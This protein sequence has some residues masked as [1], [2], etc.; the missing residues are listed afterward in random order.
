MH[1]CLANSIE[2]A[3]SLTGG[4]LLTLLLAD[5]G[6]NPKPLKARGQDPKPYQT[7]CKKRTLAPEG[8][9]SCVPM[10][11]TEKPDPNHVT[12][13]A[14]SLEG[15]ECQPRSPTRQTL[16]PTFD[17]LGEVWGQRL[18]DQCLANIYV[19]RERIKT[20]LAMKFAEQHVLDL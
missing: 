13:S 20:F 18:M 8:H 12:P 5:G 14:R 11:V 15:D 10:V 2:E 17:D 6:D 3:Q 4:K 19:K 7:R 1:Q 16:T 9:Y